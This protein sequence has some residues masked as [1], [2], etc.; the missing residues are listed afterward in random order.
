MTFTA[1][2]MDFLK[3]LMATCSS[4]N[5]YDRLQRIRI[6]IWQ[7]EVLAQKYQPL[8]ANDQAINDFEAGVDGRTDCV[9]NT[10]NTSNYLHILRDIGEL[11]GWTISS[12]Q[13]RKPLDVTAVHWTPVVI[14]TKSGDHWSVDSWFRPNGHLP[15]VM[16]MK[17]WLDEKKGWEPPFDHLNTV[18]E[19]ILDLCVPQQPDLPEVSKSEVEEE[20]EVEEEVEGEE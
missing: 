5:I 8:L 10:S 6:G 12:P 9:D 2:D 16:P 1:D 15:M 11:D 20:G 17:S 14:D 3:S 13:V 19:S 7:M 18:P 4:T